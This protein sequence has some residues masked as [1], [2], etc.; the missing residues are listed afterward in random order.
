[1][2]APPGTPG[3]VVS[4]GGVPL[5]PGAPVPPGDVLPGGMA[6]LSIVLPAPPGTPGDVV[7]VGGGVPSGDGIGI[8]DGLVIVSPAP[9]GTPGDVVSVG[10]GVPSG[11]GIGI[12]S[13]GDVVSVDGVVVV[14][15]SGAEESGD[16]WVSGVVVVPVGVVK[17]TPPGQR[18]LSGKRSH[19]ILNP[20]GESSISGVFVSVPDC[21]RATLPVTANANAVQ[22]M[23]KY[24]AFTPINLN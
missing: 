14:P 23:V 8:D 16:G 2:P 4:V 13:P 12:G 9:P 1:M 11:D 20:S 10:G 17:L 18:E 15:G 7:S 19:K 22:M 5:L 3:D 6:G 24:F 21:A